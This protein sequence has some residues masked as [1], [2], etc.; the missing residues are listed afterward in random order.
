MKR[1]SLYTRSFRC[2]HF[3]ISRDTDELK[4][5]LRAQKVSGSFEK[6][7]LGCDDFKP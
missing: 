3:S 1:S 5:A 4:M 7:T 6:R 2:I